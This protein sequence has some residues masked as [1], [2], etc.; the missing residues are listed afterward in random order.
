MKDIQFAAKNFPTK[1]IPGPDG[2]TGEFQKTFKK[3]IISI[4]QKLLWKIEEEEIFPNSFTEASM[5]LIQ[6]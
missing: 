2:F 6:N 4:L 1:K 5:S 3:E